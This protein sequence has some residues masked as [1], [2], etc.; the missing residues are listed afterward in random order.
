MSLLFPYQRFAVSQP[1][2]TLGG[3][4]YR[5]KPVIPVSLVGPTGTICREA[6]LDTGAD[7][8]LFPATYAPAIGL[9]LGQAAQ[10]STTGIGATTISVRYAELTLRLATQQEQ[11]EWQAWVGFTSAF[12]R[13]PLLGIAGCLRYFAVNFY[14]D[15]EEV[16]LTINSLYPGI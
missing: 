9:D 14:G 4:P 11:R 3:L 6:L 12:L 10:G 7:D 2:L 13:R 15:R 8:C 1:Q 16:E 5:A